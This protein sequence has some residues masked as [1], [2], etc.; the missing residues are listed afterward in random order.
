MPINDL[1][2]GSELRFERLGSI[3]LGIKEPDVDERGRQR[4]DKYGN[5][6]F[7][8]K[9]TEYFV[10]P[11]EVQK[12]IRQDR[13]TQLRVYLPFD[14][15]ERVLDAYH[16]LYVK[17]GLLCRGDGNFIDY[18]VDPQT[19]QVQVQ[20]GRALVT[21]KEGEHIFE[22]GQAVRCPGFTHDYD[23]CQHCRPVANLRV[24]IDRIFRLGYWQIA[25]GSINSM[26]NLM[27]TL[28]WVLERFGQL[29]GIPFILELRPEEIS[30]PMVIDGRP[31]RKMQTKYIL[32]LW[33]DEKWVEALIR[34]DRQQSFPQ[35]QRVPALP[36]P[37]Q[38]DEEGEPP[39][40]MP[41]DI[42]D[43]ALEGEIVEPPGGPY[44]EAQPGP[45]SL[46]AW[47]E[48]QAE[49]APEAPPELTGEGG[50]PE[51]VQE[52]CVELQEWA[53]ASPFASDPAPAGMVRAVRSSLNKKHGEGAAD[54][55][56]QAVF[57]VISLEEVT[58]AQAMAMQNK[59]GTNNGQ[60]AE[61]VEALLR[62]RPGE[63]V[64]E[65]ESGPA[66]E[67]AGPPSEEPEAEAAAN[68]DQAPTPEPT[69]E[70]PE[71]VEEE[72]SPPADVPQ[73]DPVIQAAVNRY[74]AQVAG[75]EPPEPRQEGL[76]FLEEEEISW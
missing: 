57:G 24:M 41:E 26:L 54:R 13:P 2:K 9:A 37:R 36:A 71:A 55:I 66:E 19:S 23:R 17:K 42:F 16:R 69:D 7:N 53:A 47:A 50:W 60:W 34:R 18:C 31:T 8:P 56:A 68:A 45:R 4:V 6:R 73:A 52:M 64:A 63:Q 74:G 62:F 21:F 43:G 32:H 1:L 33:P 20:G 75:V 11:D 3:R 59:L 58:K 30:C 51:S 61:A 22:P 39:E 5:P 10:C 67:E 12:A 14:E 28:H 35:P 25:T 29:T 76:P 15:P 65:P 44:P 48:K 40:G 49:P 38:G 72:A 46:P 27:G 70:E